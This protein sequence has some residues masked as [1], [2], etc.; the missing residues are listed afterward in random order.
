MGAAVLNT[1]SNTRADLRAADRF[2]FAGACAALAGAADASAGARRSQLRAAT[3][4]LGSA[5]EST[6]RRRT[7][8]P[9]LRLTTPAAVCHTSH[10]PV[11]GSAKDPPT[12]AFLPSTDAL[13][14]PPKPVGAAVRSSI[15]YAP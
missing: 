10:P 6:Q 12:V 13:A 5:A 9:A 11:A 7:C 15:V 2:A 14:V 8:T 4:P 1:A 3:S